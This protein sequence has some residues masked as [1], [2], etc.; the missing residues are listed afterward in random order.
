MA[1]LFESTNINGME[2]KN[3]FVRSGTWTGMATDDGKMTP[4]LK[5]LI[6]NVAKGGVGLI[7]PD[8]MPVHMDGR[9]ADR[10]L[11]AYDDAQISGL[12]EESAYGSS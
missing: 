5:D 6:V 1:E 10:Q 9:S 2:L 4:K 8:Y 11:G 7:V 3:R 12:S